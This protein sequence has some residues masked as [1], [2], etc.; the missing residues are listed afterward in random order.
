MPTYLRTYQPGGTF[1]FTLVTNNRR[2]FLTEPS[3]RS[4][5]HRALEETR[6]GRPF[7]LEA[8]VL[9]PQHLHCLWTMPENDGDY[10][11]RWQ[12][13]KGKFSRYYAAAGGVE[14][15]VSP[16]RRSKSERGFWQRRFWEHRVRDEREYEILCNYI[17][18]NPVK[19]G[20]AACPHGWAYS[21]FSRFV[22]EDR[23]ARD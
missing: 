2:V 23:Y 8:I 14:T 4:A 6:V 7:G 17:H 18:H 22:R 3:A 9:L 16:S 11:V 20:Y 5:L 21:F 1:F 15:W 12:I 10:S 13:I 19:H